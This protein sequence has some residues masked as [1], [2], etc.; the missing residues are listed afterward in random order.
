MT[1]EE[2]Q[3]GLEYVDEADSRAGTARS[4]PPARQT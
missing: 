1:I 3:L 2:R 4:L